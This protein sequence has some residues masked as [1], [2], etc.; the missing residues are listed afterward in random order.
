GS[1]Y[2][3]DCRRDTEFLKIVAGNKL[4]RHQLRGGAC[5]FLWNFER[6]EPT[7]AMGNHAR[8]RL[9]VVADVLVIRIR[10]VGLR[11]FR[12]DRECHQPL[13]L[14]NRERSQ[15]HRV[16]QSENRRVC[17]DAQGE[18]KNGDQ[19][20]SWVLTEDAEGILRVLG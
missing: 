17:S 13:R 18:G 7:S 6:C 1:E 10:E 16:D 2:T 19:G 4:V 12:V 5:A 15:Q 11:I 20:E 14:A 8:K 9:I 3:S